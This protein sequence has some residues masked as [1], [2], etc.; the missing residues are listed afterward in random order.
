MRLLFVVN[1]VSGYGFGK[2][3]PEKLASLSVYRD[4]EYDIRFTEYPGHAREIVAAALETG[5]YTHI[6][7]VGGDG[8][9]N[10]VGTTLI[11]SRVIFGIV[12]IGSGNGFARH[13]GYS[14]RM[15]KA[16]RQLLSPAFAPVDVLEIN[17]VYSMNVSGVGFDAEVAHEFNRLNF[18][19]IVSYVYAGMKTWF[20]YSEKDYRLTCDGETFGE[21]CFI[22]SFANSSQF[23]N[24]ASIAPHASL[25]DGLM[26]ICLLKRP[27]WW[28]VLPFLIFLMNGRIDKLSFYKVVRCREAK[29]EGNI[30]KIHIDGEAA[31]MHPPLQLKIHKGVLNAVVPKF[32][33]K[34]EV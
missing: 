33:G 16:L 21:R 20:R 8:T 18:R 28:E 25:R 9:V 24:N 3:L 34:G 10:E 23:G 14:T 12:S 32:A 19:G 5:K 30:H 11:G 27:K 6:V 1:P 26:D 29:V 4:K 13:L 22:L 7:A 2:K 31:F 15:R 17:G